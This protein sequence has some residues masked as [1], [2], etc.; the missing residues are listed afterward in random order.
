VAQ[1]LYA[2]IRAGKLD[3]AIDLTKKAQQPWR[4]AT[5]RGST[6]FQWRGICACFCGYLQNLGLIIF[7]QANL[8]MKV[9]TTMS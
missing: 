6:L 4:A 3:E 9:V 1:A 5:I 2:C 7:Q 8:G